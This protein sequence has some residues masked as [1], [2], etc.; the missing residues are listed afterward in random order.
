MGQYHDYDKLKMTTIIEL[1]FNFDG[2]NYV[3][4]GEIKRVQPMKLKMVVIMLIV[5]MMMMMRY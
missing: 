3:T 1:S 4:F 5:M 2:D